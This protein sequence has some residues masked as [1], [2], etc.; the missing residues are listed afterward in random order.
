MWCGCG[1]LKEVS[2]RGNPVLSNCYTT[3]N[4]LYYYSN[5]QLSLWRFRTIVGIKHFV[6]LLIIIFFVLVVAEGSLLYGS[7]PKARSFP[8]LR[9]TYWWVHGSHC[10]NVRKFDFIA[11]PRQSP[12]RNTIVCHDWSLG[13]LLFCRRSFIVILLIYYFGLI[14]EQSNN[15]N[16]TK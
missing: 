7:L 4:D 16:K 13:S 1:G 10:R 5:R 15:I 6:K 9:W 12:Y 3:G 14:I 2:Y 11:T 8:A